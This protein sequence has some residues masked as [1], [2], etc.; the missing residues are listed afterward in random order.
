[1]SANFLFLFVS[2]FGH[3][4]HWLP[5]LTFR[6]DTG[7]WASASVTADVVCEIK[8]VSVAF[9]FDSHGT[10]SSEAQNATLAADTL[11]QKLLKTNTYQNDQ[12]QTQRLAC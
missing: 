3:R 1:M 5:I 6:G 7:C 9:M 10:S 11:C 4:A 8:G 12:S 2:E